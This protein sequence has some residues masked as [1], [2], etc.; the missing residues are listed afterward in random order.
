MRRKTGGRGFS[1]IEI[2]VVMAV[3]AVMMGLVV[4]A[5]SNVGRARAGS[6]LGRFNAFIKKMFM[7]SIRK[8]IYVRVVVDMKKNVYWAE[9]T[10]NPFYLMDPKLQQQYEKQTDALLESYEDD[11]SFGS[12]SRDA[13]AAAGALN[14]FD[15]L[16]AKEE[17][18]TTDFYSWEN[19]VPEKRNIKALI[20]PVYEE[21]SKKTKISSGLQWTGYFSYHTPKRV[22]FDEMDEDDDE[23]ELTKRIEINIFPQ[24]RIEPFFLS[25]GSSE[26]D[27]Y[28]YLKSDFFLDTKIVRGDFEDEVTEILEGLFEEGEEEGK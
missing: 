20:K 7:K 5:I 25:I 9:K 14:L 15:K 19:F 21:L 4:P 13:G 11:N 24:G 27:V 10:D 6:E 8:G 18:D 1:I 22:V 2:L 28:Y 26:G 12:S 23:E 16:K 17:D 3:L